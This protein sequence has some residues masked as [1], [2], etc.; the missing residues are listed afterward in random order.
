MS[1]YADI[2]GS[3]KEYLLF[4]S[5]SGLRE[6]ALPEVTPA[7]PVAE[8]RGSAPEGDAAP[9][10]LETVRIDLGD[11]RRCPLCK[12][13]KN[14]VFGEGDPD[15]DILFV[16]EGPGEDEDRTGRPFVGRA[17]QL[18]TQIIENGMKISRSSVYICNIVKCRPPG[19]RTPQKEEVEACLPFLKKQ[20]EAVRP[21]AIITLGRP[22]ACA[23][24][25][26]QAPMHSL[27]GQ[28]HDWNGIPLMPVFHPSYVLRSYTVP[29][30][31]QVWEDT[32]EVLRILGML[33]G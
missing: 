28:W 11:C 1:S 32:S 25:G 20:I 30:R 31:R 6:I 3:L 27:R 15:A 16:G 7:R 12:T 24:L 17:G 18:L 21:R 22:A 5:E 33:S 10:A 9:T 19:N 2:L 13:R 14:I 26:V 23:L 8:L 29:I 4:L